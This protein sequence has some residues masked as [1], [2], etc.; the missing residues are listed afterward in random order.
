MLIESELTDESIEK[1][2]EEIDATENSAEEVHERLKQRLPL[3]Q[4]TFKGLGRIKVSDVTV[5]HITKLI[6]RQVVAAGSYDKGVA[7]LKDIRQALK[8]IAGNSN[9]KFGL[10]PMFQL[11]GKFIFSEQF[12]NDE[13]VGDYNGTSQKSLFNYLTNVYRLSPY[14]IY[15]KNIGDEMADR[16]EYLKIH[17]NNGVKS[18]ALI[19]VF[20]HDQFM[21]V[22]EVFTTSADDLSKTMLTRLETFF[23]VLSI[24]F[25]KCI[26]GLNQAVQETI[27]TKFTSLQS[28][29]QWR[30]NQAAWQYMQNNAIQE[31]P[32]EIEDIEFDHVYPL[33]GA[34]DVKDSTV[35]RNRALREDTICHLQLLIETLT[36]IK[37]H[38]S[39]GLL[40]E[41]ISACKQW[42]EHI[43]D[44]ASVLQEGELIY[45]F[46]N[47]ICCFLKEL[48]QG[49][50]EIAIEVEKYMNAIDENG[51]IV[52]EKSRKLEKSM[53]M[54]INTINNLVDS[55][56][57]QAQIDFPCFFEKFRTD[58][59]EYDIYIGQSI[60]PEQPFKHIF[61]QNL[62]LLQ[63]ANMIEIAKCVR[64]LQAQI[65]VAVDITQLIFVNPNFINIRFRR[66]ER[67][68]DVEGAYNIRYHIV[69]KRI[70]KVLIK[71]SAERLTASGK[72]AIVYFNQRE[73]DEYLVHIRYL[74][75]RQLLTDEIELLELEQLQGVVGL[76]A[77]RVAIQYQDGK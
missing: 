73:A 13:P 29:V 60:A 1:I 24:V 7:Y 36:K 16:Y 38:T 31:G 5:P 27:K 66:D 33:Y 40:N 53:S 35:N 54:V 56:Q 43:N 61:I 30:F 50:P 44:E 65:P 59:V 62:R 12:G 8:V 6:A 77:L 10:F 28:S 25:K 26:D 71:N 21:G 41:K 42:Q 69:K 45:F 52:S 48:A 57:Q 34:I 17:R 55:I 14:R 67:R 76:K 3:F 49:K 18:F 72:I 11:N 58:G 22:L 19:P 9:L 39:F 23:P 64:D 20:Y 68:F 46:E 4:F 47:D 63:L 2:I 51:G 15:L 37:E 74:Q 70:D 75:S 32:T